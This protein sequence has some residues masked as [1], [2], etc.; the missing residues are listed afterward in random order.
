MYLY[1]L[2]TD[3]LP[4][5][6]TT[7]NVPKTV[8][9]QTILRSRLLQCPSSVHFLFCTATITPKTATPVQQATQ[10]MFL[11]KSIVS[12]QI[13]IV[14]ILFVQIYILVSRCLIILFIVQRSRIY[15]EIQSPIQVFCGEQQPGKEKL[16]SIYLRICLFLLNSCYISISS[17]RR[18]PRQTAGAFCAIRAIQFGENRRSLR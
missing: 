9:Y 6:S 5:S 11:H 14:H 10:P 15:V 13:V 7:I 4:R 1:R 8:Q 3:P 16:Y 18:G 2:S 17:S 12:N